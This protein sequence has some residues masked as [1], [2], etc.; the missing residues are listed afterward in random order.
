VLYNVFSNFLD[1]AG[2]LCCLLE[3]ISVDVDNLGYNTT[4]TC[5]PEDG[6]TVSLQN[7]GICLQSQHGITTQNTNIN[8]FTAVRT[9]NLTESIFVIFLMA[10][11]DCKIAFSLS[12]SFYFFFV[13][14]IIL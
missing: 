6:D 4:W 5:S 13:L 11:G 10:F 12:F 7:V 1:V 2:N 14:S 8:I 3:S 9:S